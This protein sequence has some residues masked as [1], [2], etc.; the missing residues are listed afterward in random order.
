[1]RFINVRTDPFDRICLPLDSPM[2][3]SNPLLRPISWP[4]QDNIAS[5]FSRP[6]NGAEQMYKIAVD[7]YGDGQ[8]STWYKIAARNMAEIVA[9]KGSFRY[10]L[11]LEIPNPVSYL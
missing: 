6:I 5:Q 8:E 2:G 11:K 1:M 7:V 9:W 4:P 3:E 10:I